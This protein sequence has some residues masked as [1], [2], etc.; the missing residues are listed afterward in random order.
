MPFFAVVVW[1]RFRDGGAFGVF[2]CFCG[3]VSVVGVV[4]WWCFCVGVVVFFCG[5]VVVFL[6]WGGCVSVVFLCGGVFVVVWW[7]HLPIPH[8]F[9]APLSVMMGPF[10][11]QGK[12]CLAQLALHPLS[13]REVKGSIPRGFLL[14]WWWCGGVF[15]VVWRR[16]CDGGAFVAFCGGGVVVFVV[17]LCFCGGVIWWCFCKGVFLGAGVL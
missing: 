17:W 12:D 2:L 6:W 14:L 15:V 16:F 5:G 4:V 9:L 1:W 3:G 7:W 11:P 8:L 13:L 10:D